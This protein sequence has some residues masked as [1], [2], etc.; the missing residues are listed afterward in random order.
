MEIC[1][2]V[3]TYLG[4]ISGCVQETIEERPLLAKNQ[5]KNMLAPSN[6]EAT[7]A[8]EQQRR[9]ALSA[10][11]HNTIAEAHCMPRFLLFI[12]YTQKAW[13]MLLRNPQNRSE[14]VRPVVEG[15]GGKVEV[16]YLS[17]TDY[18]V[19]AIVEMPDDATMAALSMAFMAQFAVK[20]I[21]TIPLLT[22]DQAIEAMQKGRKAA[23]NP[24]ETNPMLARNE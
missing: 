12:A 6:K 14:A 2:F 16:G 15:L 18:E 11:A 23:Y 21:K 22:W 9:Q 1:E 7:E 19:V 20:T 13:D 17:Q 4:F 24:P 5:A 10:A 3:R 8:T